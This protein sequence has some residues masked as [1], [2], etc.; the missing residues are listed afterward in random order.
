[1]TTNAIDYDARQAFEL[2]VGI[3]RPRR[4]G[5]EAE[6]QVGRELAARL[7]AAGYQVQAEPFR[8]HDAHASFLILEIVACQ[9]L[10]A[11]SIGLLALGSPVYTV[12]ATLLIVVL[13]LINRI[14]RAAQQGSLVVEGAHPGAWARLCRRLG[15]AYQAANY[16]ASLPQSGESNG[17]HLLL[18]AHYDSKS[19]RMPLASRMTFFMLGIGGALLFAL[20]MLLSPLMP[21]LVTPA[22]LLGGLALLA[23]V[24]LWFLDLGNDSPGAIDNASS[25]GVVVALAEALARQP[26]LCR[27]LDLRVL[28]TSAE[29]V[30]TMG[31][32]AYVQRH[33]AELMRQDRSGRLYVFNFDGVGVNGTLR[34]VGKGERS[35]AADEPS[36]RHLVRQA[37][38]ELSG[39]IKSFNLPGALYD[40]LPF[41]EAGLDA[42]TLVAVGKTSLGV[43]TP[44]DNPAALDLAGFQRAGCVAVKVIQALLELPRLEQP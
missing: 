13:A 20:L 39:E 29:E 16:V 30:S 14:N 33:Q 40:H 12:T 15:K 27:R 9:A 41:A 5:S 32:V 21:A 22:L 8:F 2:A 26:E 43:H 10:V 18:V 3:S 28:L 42:G 24:P 17:L 35:A 37:C 4:V 6:V 7:E 11:I 31:A 34:W 38:I 23:G 44:R 19:Q 36:L 1:M 25:V